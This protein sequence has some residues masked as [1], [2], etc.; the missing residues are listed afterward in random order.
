MAN[1]QTLPA[2]VGVTPKAWNSIGVM[3]FAPPD[4]G[5]VEGL[6]VEAGGFEDCFFETDVSLGWAVEGEGLA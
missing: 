6:E 4:A 1:P 3:H 5:G 2:K